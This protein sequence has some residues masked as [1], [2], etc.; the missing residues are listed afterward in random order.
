MSLNSENSRVQYWGNSSA[1]SPYPVT[2]VFYNES[3]LKVVITDPQGVDTF[4][5]PGSGYSIS[6]A[7]SEDGG[8]IVT[9]IAYSDKHKVTIYREVDATQKTV[10]EENADFPAKSHERALDKLT[11]L[12]QQLGRK[13]RQSLRFRESDG[14]LADLAAVPSTLIGLD[15]GKAP[16]AMTAAEVAVW[17]NI[18]QAFFGQGSV[19]F[20]NTADRD[21]AV[22]QFLGQVGV[23]ID[24]GAM[25][26]GTALTAGSWGAPIAG[27]ANG[28]IVTAMLANGMLSA[29]VAGRA[30]MADAFLTLAKFG[31]GMFT[32]NA[33]GR[34]PFAAG[35]V[36]S[37]LCA[38]GLWVA[39]APVGAV[40]QTVTVEYSVAATISGSI[41]YDTSVPQIGEGT[42]IFSTSITPQSITSVLL[43][44]VQ[45]NIATGQGRRAIAAVFIN[46]EANAIV[47]A[48]AN[49]YASDCPSTMAFA[50]MH[51]PSSISPVAITVR[52]GTDAPGTP[53]FMNGDYLGAKFGSV[54]TV[55]SM[56]S[57]LTIQE[58][59][60]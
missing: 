37:T 38:S 17:L 5:T 57:L 20:L 28:S 33:A 16:R 13:V 51:A 11:M 21:A 49:S 31:T 48:V 18:S 2:F 36:D 19:T 55:N 8:S 56:A 60:A 29:D 35:F 15:A 30:K 1:S 3:D 59:K 39:L 7:G 14:D 50:R 23:Q 53:F 47:A 45:L 25:Y 40:L 10:Y 9:S 6:G 52:V 32:A 44:R 22:P 54:S 46:G 12:V 27:I 42:Q 41:P 26:T 4:L 43:I 24:N 34:M 58:L